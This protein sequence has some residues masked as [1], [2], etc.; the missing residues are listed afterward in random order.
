M[1]TL[2]VSLSLVIALGVLGCA[3]T[4]PNGA[5]S[6]SFA[7]AS[8]SVTAAPAMFSSPATS[9]A[10]DV[11]IITKAEVVLRKVELKA[12]ENSSCDVTPTPST[13][14]EFQSGPIRLQIPTTP[15]A[16]TQVSLPIP[17]GTYTG[18]E[19]N[20]HKVSSG[21]SAEA[22]FRAANPDLIGKSIVVT[23]TFNGNPFTYVSSMDVEQELS[24]VPNLVISGATTS[25]NLTVR[26][27][28]GDWFKTS[29]GTLIDPNTANEGQPNE[30]L[31]NSNIQRSMKAFEDKDKDGN[32]G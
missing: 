31:V 1:K 26:V 17:V 32:E 9:S 5:V 23:G 15:G 7:G 20:I 3:N 29:S 12:V 4:G 21:D 11:L 28:L 30:G 10:G 22:A 24:L 6:L 18:V 19:F 13:C 2:T 14:E 27:T 8:A 25:T 16:V